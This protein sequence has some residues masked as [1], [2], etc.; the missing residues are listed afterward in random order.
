ML[1]FHVDGKELPKG[2]DG[3]QESLAARFLE[4]LCLCDLFKGQPSWRVTVRV[5]VEG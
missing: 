2:T 5:K 4:G 1:S 3:C